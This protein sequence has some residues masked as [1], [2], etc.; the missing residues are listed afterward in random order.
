ML[1]VQNVSSKVKTVTVL[2]QKYGTSEIVIYWITCDIVKGIAI[3]EWQNNIEKEANDDER[4]QSVVTT[5]L[6]NNLE[7]TFVH[8]KIK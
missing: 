2:C 4:I 8:L 3:L 1:R 7:M 6:K 5:N